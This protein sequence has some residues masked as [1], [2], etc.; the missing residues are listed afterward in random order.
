RPDPDQLFETLARCCPF[1]IHACTVRR[2]MVDRIGAFDPRYR[3]GEDWDFWQRVARAGGRFIRIDTEVARY[4]MRSTS[5]ALDIQTL[6]DTGPAIID[7]GQPTDPRVRD[8]DL[9]VAEGCP[10]TDRSAA[11]LAFA[12][13]PAGI[14]LGA[15]EDAR[16][17]LDAVSHDRD[18]DMDASAVAASIFRSGTLPGSVS[19]NR[20]PGTWPG[21]PR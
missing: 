21:A 6:L 17:V 13:W 5:A 11:R 20:V 19:P 3:V 18:A 14:L 9:R 10:A 2:R 12:C 15:G 1:A 4:R 8:P 16:G 7:R